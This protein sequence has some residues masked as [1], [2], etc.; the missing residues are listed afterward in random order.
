MDIEDASGASIKLILCRRLLKGPQMKRREFIALVGIAFLSAPAH[1]QKV[2]TVGLLGSGS[3]AAQKEWTAAFVR[4]LAQ[5]GWTEGGN[6]KIEYR[7]AEGRNERFAEMASELVRLNVDLILT[8]NTVPTLAVKRATSTIPI[9]F[10][11]A[12]DPVGSGIVT[13]LA[14][15]GGNVTG[16]SGQAPDTAGK[17]IE[18][19]REM[20]P[21]FNNL[22]ILTETANPYAA[23]DV[24]EVQRAART[25]NVH[26]QT[27]EIGPGDKIDTAIDSLKG[28]VQALYVLPIP[29]FFVKRAEISAASLAAG[30]PTMY[31]IREYVQ[32]GGLISYGP[33]WPSMWR[34]A[35]DVVVKVLNGTKPGD[36]PVEQPTEF[37]L[38]INARTAKT[39][40]LAV[41]AALFTRADEVIE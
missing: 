16:L 15:P 13:S 30:L 33:N 22:G 19:L 18:L 25:L 35:A 38:V 4:R 10:A 39:L 41:P 11:T 17:R 8:H 31:V 29:R 21:G 12:G 26:V 40:G 14:R 28:R 27:K 24:R 37:D 1:A 20:T 9:V 6:L 5:L 3:E 34:R 23:L 7:W 2:R 36:I 32:A